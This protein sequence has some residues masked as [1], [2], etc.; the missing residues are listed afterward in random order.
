[1]L[2]SDTN[3]RIRTF[4]LGAAFAFIVA[5]APATAVA[6]PA[7]P[8]PQGPC[9]A[10]GSFNLADL[11]DF[12]NRE[13][14]ISGHAVGHGDNFGPI[15]GVEVRIVKR[16]D[17]T[18]LAYPG[19]DTINFNTPT[20]QCGDISC[21]YNGMRWRGE[22]GFGGAM[23]SGCGGA[24]VACTVT[25]NP[26]GVGDLGE[27]YAVFY[28][29]HYDGIFP[30]GGIAFAFYTPPTLYPV[31]LDT[32]DT[33]GGPL[34]VRPGTVVY[35]VREGAN[36][37][38]A[39]CLG[40]DWIGVAVHQ[41][42]V[43]VPACVTLIRYQPYNDNWLFWGHLPNDS[44]T[45]TIVGAPA[46]D[47][48]LPLRQ[49]PAAYRRLTVTPKGDDN[50]TSMVWEDRPRLAVEV[51][52]RTLTMDLGTTQTVEVTVR[53]LPGDT[54]SLGGVSL[55]TGSILVPELTPN[56][57]LQV[58]GAVETVPP[59][60]LTLANG[61][62]RTFA[63]EV[64]AVG[65]GVSSI[66]ANATGTDDLGVRQQVRHGAS[67]AV[68]YKQPPPVLDDRPGSAEAPRPPVIQQAL[69]L[70]PGTFATD[71]VQGFVQGT[72]DTTV[73]VSLA[74]SETPASDRCPQAMS[75]GGVTSQGSFPVDIG[76]DGIGRFS[77]QRALTLGWYVYGVTTAGTLYSAVGDCVRVADTTTTVSIGDVAV[78]EGTNAD[79]T[80][81]MTFTISLSE[82]STRTVTVRV[83]TADGTADEG[84]GAAQT[85]SDYSPLPATTLTFAP[86][87]V[88][89]AV[90]IRAVADAIA[91]PD[92]GFRVIL[93]NPV[94]VAL[95]PISEGIGT[96]TDDDA[97]GTERG[98]EVCGTWDIVLR[99][100]SPG[101]R[102]Y[103]TTLVIKSYDPDTGAVTGT[104]GGRGK[105]KGSL[106]GDRLRLR[107]TARQ[108]T[109]AVTAI[110]ATLLER[111]GRLTLA[112][113]YRT[114]IPGVTTS[115]PERNRG[116]Y[117]GTLVKPR[118][119]SG[120]AP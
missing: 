3:S 65:L 62:S 90:V 9:L 107:V 119:P 70:T 16:G 110:V 64:Q 112:G 33:E 44:G 93:S 95:G 27:R 111:N 77:Q 47:A 23:V 32:V 118:N 20:R 12:G 100:E 51:K 72:P 36:P 60:G 108:V 7:P 53:A 30:V 71:I 2:G 73:T 21:P 40:Q 10:R 84:L 4:A 83:A 106:I 97:A 52:P 89:K 28:G 29:Q 48:G 58:V 59:E 26:S 56:A 49:R 94:N 43:E 85:P 80:T 87:E 25:Y 81:P 42:T 88:S 39:E 50:R 116:S 115:D 98:C 24:D 109:P 57:A 114:T 22:R 35:A 54:G 6:S 113:T 19:G 31:E 15:A 38:Q 61:E 14:L 46:G 37:V 74:S 8:P 117:K 75:G 105:A 104:A 34:S 13:C 96:I 45:W 102:D 18:T 63:V 82:A 99:P 78:D 66:V 69:D 101:N 67:I 55:G 120:K 92:E 103:K 11:H 76:A 5:L 1:M 68:A 86:G 41:V 79:A 91:E 17:P